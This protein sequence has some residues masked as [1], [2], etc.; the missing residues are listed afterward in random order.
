MRIP[1][2]FAIVIPGLLAVLT[3][4]CSKM[5]TGEAADLRKSFG[6][7][8]DMP[9]LDLGAVELRV[10]TPKRVRVGWDKYCTV[11]PTLQ[12]NGS[13]QLNLLYESQSE[14]IDGVKIQPYSEQARSVLSPRLIAMAMKSKSWTCF[15]EMRAHFV[16]AIQP[17][18]IQ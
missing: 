1:Q 13:V 15:P 18:I 6:L 4:S 12:T 16:V 14:V 2:I 10:G 9:L 11:T 7:P 5:T 17:I 8:A 3:A